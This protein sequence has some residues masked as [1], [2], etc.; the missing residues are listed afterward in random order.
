MDI[1]LER[2]LSLMSRKEDGKFV[3]G[4]KKEFA[5]RLGV[6]NN[7]VSMWIAGT[8]KSYEQKLYQIADIYG[9]SV[10]WLKGET[11]EKQKTPTSEEGELKE[12][13]ERL[14]SRSECRMLF[15]LADGATKEDVE[16]TVKILEALRGIE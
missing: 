4:A 6:S 11:D 15:S 14:S 5:D 10:A 3:H 16:R 13:L 2:I 7:L 8:S 12:L 1:T 9:V